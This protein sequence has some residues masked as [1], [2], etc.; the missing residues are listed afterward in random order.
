MQNE[1]SSYRRGIVDP[2]SQIDPKTLNVSHIPQP[3]SV[4]KKRASNVRSSMAYGGRQSMIGGMRGQSALGGVPSSAKRTSVGG[5]N[6]SQDMVV[7]QSVVRHGGIRK[8]FVPGSAA[9]GSQ[10][11]NSGRPSSFG[12]GGS[13][14]SNTMAS[15]SQSKDPR[16]LRDKA[17]QA[18]MQEEIYEYLEINQFSV[19]MNHPLK[20]KSL[21]NPT[22]KDFVVIFQWLYKRMDPGYRFTK[23]IEQE[24]YQLLKAIRYPYL[25]SI[26][27]SQISAVGGRNWCIFL[28]LLHW[29]VQLNQSLEHAENMDYRTVEEGSFVNKLVAKYLLKSYKAF[30]M[31]EDHHFVEYYAEAEDEFNQ[32]A[33]PKVEE[34][35]QMEKE[36]VELKEKYA[37]LC[38]GTDI[39]SAL[40]KKGEALES[41]LVKFRAY[42][43]AYEKKKEKWSAVLSKIRDELDSSE[44]QKIELEKEKQH[45]ESQIAAQGLTPGDIDKMNA[46]R[47]KLAKALDSIS[48]RIEEANRVVNEKDQKAQS[49]LDSLDRVIQ[50]YNTGCYRIGVIPSTSRNCPKGMNFEVYLEN[51]LSEE[52]LGQRPD[53]LLKGIDLRHVSKPALLQLR[54]QITARMHKIQDESIKIQEM[55][56]LLNDQLNDKKEEIETLEAKLATGKNSFDELYETMNSEASSSHAEIERLERELRAMKLSNQ[57]GILQLEQRCQSIAIE[58]DQL[59][60]SIQTAREAMHADVEKFIDSTIDFKMHIQESLEG[61]EGFVIEE[62]ENHDKEDDSVDVTM[63]IL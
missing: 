34:I 17:H 11:R 53:V 44:A 3:A 19:E 22:Q 13:M 62:I 31:D 43:N 35:E 23:A 21:V 40:E 63:T 56:D 8:S 18:M 24:V 2:L 20:E 51:P 61:Y 25:E 1:F 60:H 46:E 38:R 6:F 36:N 29:M 12:V 59:K 4:S 15:A 57:Q 50:K 32:Y 10:G 16:P 9:S 30:L 49:T 14:F 28:G 33:Q 26:N 45:I 41:D 27:K 39:L 47:D 58:Y 52:N 42:I 37:S 54:N 5:N 7:P 48:V 55:L